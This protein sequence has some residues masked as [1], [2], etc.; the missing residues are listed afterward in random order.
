MVLGHEEIIEA[1]L[2]SQNSL[3]Y[4]PDQPALAGFV[5]LGEVAVVDGDT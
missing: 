1:E 2:V 3:A 5:N 4:L